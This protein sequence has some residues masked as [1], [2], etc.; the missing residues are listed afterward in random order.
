MKPM[1]KLIIASIVLAIAVLF[2]SATIAQAGQYDGPT[3]MPSIDVDKMI[4]VPTGEKGS[5]DYVYRDNVSSN[6]YLFAPGAFVWYRV[7]VKN[8]SGRVLNDVTI[9]DY[10]PDYITLYE[11]PGNYDGR[12]IVINVGTLQSNEEK[13]YT[14]KARISDQAN[15]PAD[16]SLVCP[17]NRVR[18]YNG[19]TSDE[20]TAQLCAGRQVPGVKHVPQAGAEDGLLIMTVASA[21]GYVGLKLRKIS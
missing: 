4:A 6:D 1:K 2:T 18:A 7:K 16:S 17:V 10:A 19:E 12:D 21:L 8:T 11:N 3:P 20:D 9:R 14:L 13:E 5:T 15:F